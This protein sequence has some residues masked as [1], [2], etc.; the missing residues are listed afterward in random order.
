MI[1]VYLRK[2]VSTHAGNC[3]FRACNAVIACS[4]LGDVVDTASITESQIDEGK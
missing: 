4:G 3:I 2:L 1:N